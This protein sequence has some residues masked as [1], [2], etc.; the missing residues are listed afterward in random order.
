MPTLGPVGREP[1]YIRVS[2]LVSICTS[3]STRTRVFSPARRSRVET[4]KPNAPSSGTQIIH[5]YLLANRASPFANTRRAG[6][7][8]EWGDSGTAY[9]HCAGPGF[10][11]G[12]GRKLGET[13][14]RPPRDATRLRRAVH[15]STSTQSSHPPKACTYVV[16]STSRR[17]KK[18]SLKRT[19]RFA[20]ECKDS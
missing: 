7:A 11:K 12:R 3:T 18:K 8:D 10:K 20:P 9:E 17:G 6:R 1:R 14:A 13:I 5:I 19:L 2:V 16:Q 15:L 4:A